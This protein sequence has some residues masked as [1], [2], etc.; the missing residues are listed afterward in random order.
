M[1]LCPLL[2]VAAGMA[3][4]R[5]MI[6]EI[7]RR[8]LW[9]VLA[10]YAVAS[11]VIWQ[12]VGSLYEWIGLP[13]WVPGAA[14]VL[15]LVGLPIVVAT[16]F[17][18][19]GGPAPADA[20]PHAV[21]SDGENDDSRDPGAP[22]SD[23]TFEASGRLPR[24]QRL[25]TWRR[26]ITGGILAFAALGIASA[27]F[28]GMRALGIGPAATLISSGELSERDV[29]V[30]ARFDNATGDESLAR[31][32]TEGLRIQLS[33]S[34]VLR[35]ADRSDIDRALDRMQ[36]DAEGGIGEELALEIATREGYKAVLAGAVTSAGGEYLFSA[37]LVNAADGGVMA[38]F[39]ATADDSTEII[40][41]VDELGRSIREEVGESLRDVRAN[42]PLARVS[43][44]SLEALRR[45]TDGLRMATRGDYRGALALYRE[46][47][48]ID[49]TFA[50][51]Y[52]K[53]GV[54]APRIGLPEDQWVPALTRAYER[55]D[56][57]PEIER[58]L[59]VGTYF[60]LVEDDPEQAILAYRRILDIDPDQTAALNNLAVI[61]FQQDRVEE[62]ATLYTRLL[63]LQPSVVAW[64]NLART[65]GELGRID[66]ARTVL[67][68][69]A[70]RYP[71]AAGIGRERLHLEASY[72]PRDVARRLAD[73][74]AAAH[75]NDR[76]TQRNAELYHFYLDAVEGR[77]RE[78]LDH[79]ERRLELLESQG[80]HDLI[81]MQEV[82]MLRLFLGH[83]LPRRARDVA[84]S[85][86]ARPDSLTTAFPRFHGSL[87]RA[88]ALLGDT[89]AAT[90]HLAE[91]ER[92]V[93]DPPQVWM[94]RQRARVMAAEG[95][96]RD[97][98][99]AWFRA[100]RMDEC[101][102]ECPPLFPARMY[103]ALAVPDSAIAM[104][105]AYLEED[106]IHRIT[107]RAYDLPSVLLALAALH[108]EHGSRERAAV[109]YS[110]YTELMAGADP[111]FQPRVETARRRLEKLAGEGD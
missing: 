40:D 103:E 52:R 33:Q 59:A 61:L 104:Y 78:A 89:A 22:T 1:N 13:D 29:V 6:H 67:R 71:D 68:N 64:T 92:A 54:T 36:T 46:A 30:L 20:V 12:V 69:G 79:H 60:S 62:A 53:I 15:L 7:H 72:A 19:E 111:V 56:R 88:Y 44:G 31:V 26:A 102:D 109:L 8:S 63:G 75:P 100:D 55:R 39:G 81:W 28:L 94:T 66:S 108:E 50:M 10:I 74:L 87:A 83:E 99:E 97:A 76:L 23:R 16:A 27:G 58:Q 65:L 2:P 110:R 73:S 91:F 101:R 105:E 35:L 90:A 5:D 70:R 37:R 9:Q 107:D 38:T 85:L 95:R 82:R 49:S 17:V 34:P 14:L 77:L 3:S 11:W 24:S 57:L 98:L 43:T 4:L 106:D 86:T 48:G 18:Q 25:F 21:A 96:Y 32:V 51:A 42:P 41:A 93:D 45:Y 84:D 80:R 47:T